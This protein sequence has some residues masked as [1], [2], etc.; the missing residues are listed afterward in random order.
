VLVLE[1]PVSQIPYRPLGV[2]YEY[3]YRCAEYEHE[4]ETHVRLS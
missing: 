1:V 2:E 3:E 4:C